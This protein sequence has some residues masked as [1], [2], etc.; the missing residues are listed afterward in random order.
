MVAVQNRGGKFA[1]DGLFS[2]GLS[3]CGVREVSDEV[4]DVV[5]GRP[6][7]DVAGVVRIVGCQED[8]GP[9]AGVLFA[10]VNGDLE[11]AILDEED[12][13]PG[14]AVDGVGFHAW[15]EGGDVNFE[16][17]H[18]NGGV[19]EDMAHLAGRGRVWNE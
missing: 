6:V 16:L 9:R 18:G 1:G 12:F 17:V 8:H 2:G 14:M 4:D 10:T 3:G 19:V 5:G 7:A 11:V 15:I 13:F